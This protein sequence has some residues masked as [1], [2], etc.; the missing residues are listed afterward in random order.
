MI[1]IQINIFTV[2]YQHQSMWQIIAII[3][4]LKCIYKHL[5]LIHI[6]V[7]KQ[8]CIC[9]R[10]NGATSPRDDDSFS[11]DILKSDEVKTN[12]IESTTS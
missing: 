12:H 4:A 9:C 11:N 10:F 7:A 6:N 5:S 8:K 1:P 2:K 3:T